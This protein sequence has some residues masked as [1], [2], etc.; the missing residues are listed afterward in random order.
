[1]ATRLW[2]PSRLS[3]PPR[4]DPPWR[5]SPPPS[6]N[7]DLDTHINTHTHSC[8]LTPEV[9]LSAEATGREPVDGWHL[10]D[11]WTSFE[12]GAGSCLEKLLCSAVDD[13]VHQKC[14][15]CIHKWS[16]LKKALK[17]HYFSIMS[18]L[19][20]ALR[21]TLPLS[22]WRKHHAKLHFKTWHFIVT[23]LISKGTYQ[24]ERNLRC[25][26]E[27]LLSSGKCAMNG[28]WCTKQHSPEQNFIF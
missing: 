28:R 16:S 21:H 27:L 2:R 23:L 25:F 20:L 12:P 5:T 8:F 14:N 24:A 18:C 19:V 3:P 10:R 6:P 11:K 1:M 9:S 13:G 17:T 15:G 7:F 22:V 4:L 26:E